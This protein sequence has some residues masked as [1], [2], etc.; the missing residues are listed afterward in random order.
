MGKQRRTA[1]LLI[2]LKWKKLA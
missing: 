2:I 1:M